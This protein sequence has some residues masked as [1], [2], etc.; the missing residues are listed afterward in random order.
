M[1]LV[2]SAFQLLKLSGMSKLR[3]NE[4]GPA[5]YVQ[6]VW[7]MVGRSTVR[8]LHRHALTVYKI[9]IRA[10]NADIWQTLVLK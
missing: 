8:I 5:Y 7:S 4:C 6:R 1:I 2:I 3:T 10:C 9:N